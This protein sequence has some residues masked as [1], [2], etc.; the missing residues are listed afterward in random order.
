MGVVVGVEWSGRRQKAGC[1]SK[2]KMQVNKNATKDLQEARVQVTASKRKS[3]KVG[4]KNSPG[5]PRVQE[6]SSATS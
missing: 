2:G 4:P 5:G 6:S 3:T 1:K